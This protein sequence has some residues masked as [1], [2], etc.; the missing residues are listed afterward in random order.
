M[1]GDKFEDWIYEFAASKQP[2]I[3]TKFPYQIEGFPIEFE[4]PFSIYKLVPN[5]NGGF[6]VRKLKQNKD[7]ENWRIHCEMVS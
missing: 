3:Y 7:A 5:N 2:E 4:D 6:N 1:S